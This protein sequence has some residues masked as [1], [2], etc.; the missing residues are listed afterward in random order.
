[1]RRF[2]YVDV[3]KWLC[4]W[5]DIDKTNGP[6][7]NEHGFPNLSGLWQLRR[8][9]KWGKIEIFELAMT[10]KHRDWLQETKFLQ[11]FKKLWVSVQVRCPLS[12]ESSRKHRIAGFSTLGRPIFVKSRRCQSWK[13][14]FY[15][16]NSQK[17][18]KRFICWRIFCPPTSWQRI[19]TWLT[20][21]QKKLRH[22]LLGYH[23]I[24][25]NSH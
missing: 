7:V 21:H 5:C 3:V 25:T 9:K 17:L 6:R 11:K 20:D 10:R 15:L 13:L 23:N 22:I 19:S 2:V 1:M 4:R 12:L 18:P 16:I 14:P 24:D 8:V